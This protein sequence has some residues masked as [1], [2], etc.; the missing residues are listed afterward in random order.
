MYRRSGPS[1]VYQHLN[2]TVSLLN[3]SCQGQG[4]VING[5][6]CNCCLDDTR[7]SSSIHP[8]LGTSS[9]LYSGWDQCDDRYWSRPPGINLYS[10]NLAS[11]RQERAS[12]G[13]LRNWLSNVSWF[14]QRTG[15]NGGED[16]E[17]STIS[18]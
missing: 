1:S 10:P 11:E 8:L 12:R 13:S 15:E 14:N 7:L 16:Q 17:I 5:S 4:S 9:D 3:T 18:G 6:S 2:P